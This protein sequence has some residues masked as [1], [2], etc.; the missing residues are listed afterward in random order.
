MAEQPP[1]LQ[2]SLPPELIR[3]IEQLVKEAVTDALANKQSAPATRYLTR[4]E[5]CQK[6]NISLPTLSRY[7]GKGLLSAQKIGT[8]VLFD[9][10]KLNECLQKSTER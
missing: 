9:E 1:R 2:I 7:I 8:R 10:S 6:L 5:V 4:K 3:Y